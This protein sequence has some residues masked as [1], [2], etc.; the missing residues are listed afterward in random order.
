MPV[1]QDRRNLQGFIVPT[2][3]AVGRVAITLK[4]EFQVLTGEMIALVGLFRI[5]VGVDLLRKERFALLRKERFGMV[6]NVETGQVFEEIEGEGTI[7]V[8]VD[9]VLRF[10]VQSGG[11]FARPFG[12]CIFCACIFCACIFC[13]CIF[14][15]GFG[16]AEG[17]ETG[18]A[19]GI[20]VHV[21]VGTDNNA[22]HT[23]VFLA[24]GLGRPLA[25]GGW[26]GTAGEVN[27]HPPAPDLGRVRLGLQI[28]EFDPVV[29]FDE[30]L[31]VVKVH[32]ARLDVDED[33]IG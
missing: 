10:R 6:G 27:L 20:E 7:G 18:T 28:G 23:V 12:A 32:R 2:G 22:L 8:D 21:H 1:A 30:V 29:G 5:A 15:I 25:G 33:V 17:Q 24:P 4:F 16:V 14:P 11:R 13:A 31:V 9:M 19:V 26:V 3:R